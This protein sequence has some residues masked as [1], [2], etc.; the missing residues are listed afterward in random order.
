ME[1]LQFVT[2]ILTNIHRCG[3][4]A[5]ITKTADDAWKG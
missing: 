1:D 4:I 3:K 2:H 5:D